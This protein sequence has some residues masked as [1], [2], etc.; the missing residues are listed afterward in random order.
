MRKCVFRTVSQ[1]KRLA[2]GPSCL[3]CVQGCVSCFM[4]SSK[5]CGNKKLAGLSG[6]VANSTFYALC[7]HANGRGCGGTTLRVLGTIS[8]CPDSSK[9]F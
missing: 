3:R 2:N 5:G 6:F 1:L 7:T 9:R 4:S 8:S